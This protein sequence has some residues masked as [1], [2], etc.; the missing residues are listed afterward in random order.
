MSYQPIKALRFKHALMRVLA[1]LGAVHTPGQMYSH[2]LQTRAGPLHC[3]AKDD[4]FAGRFEDVGRAR[5]EVA[6]GS[7]N[8]FSGKWNWHWRRADDPEEA[9]EM[10]IELVR[11]MPMVRS[12]QVDLKYPAGDQPHGV[13]TRLTYTYRDASNYK[14]TSSLV[15]YG[16]MSP[17]QA[18][19]VLRSLDDEGFIPGQVGLPDLQDSFA[20]CESYWDPE[21]DDAWHDLDCIELTTDK[22]ELGAVSVHDLTDRF[23]DVVMTKGWD[24]QYRPAFYE[25]MRQRFEQ[26]HERESV[27]G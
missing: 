4:W 2:V 20:G 19:A 23:M 10:F 17:E 22:P 7:L 1:L 26:R 13:N 25:A 24:V 18:Q 3:D 15:L 6:R 27:A 16:A 11:I 12:D 14:A 21:Q 9:R 5:A 8:T